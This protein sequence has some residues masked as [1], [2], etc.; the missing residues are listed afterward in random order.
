MDDLITID[1]YKQAKAISSA[2][3]DERLGIIVPSVS[4]LVKTYCGNSFVDY[5]TNPLT[6]YFDVEWKQNTIQLT[7][8][9]L[10]AV[11]EVWERTTPAE[12]YIQLLD[13]LTEYVP[14]A[15]KDTITRVGASWPLGVEAIKVLYTAGYASLP[16]DL[17][18]VLVDLVHYFYREEHKITKQLSGASISNPAGTLKGNVGFPDH[19]K[20]VLDLYKQI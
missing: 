3:D 8:S 16:G 5:V 20:R 12:D 11:A 6:E 15:R 18:L 9:P 4:Q 10:I 17:T 2:K 1:T 14:S 7:E 19:I 13:D